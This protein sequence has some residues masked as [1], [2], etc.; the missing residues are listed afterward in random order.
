MSLLQRLLGAPTREERARLASAVAA[1]DRE[2]AANIEL[3]ALWDQTHQAATFENGEFARHA[4]T[5]RVA[6][7]SA[8]ALVADVYERIPAIE[9]AMERR[10]PVNS[11][12]TS[13]KALVESWEGDVREGQRVLRAAVSAP[14]ASVWSLLKERVFPRSRNRTNGR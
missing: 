3:A 2:L 7:P 10:G 11:I 1:V 8:A 6:A 5:I 14:P 4:S 12:A 9:S 13:D